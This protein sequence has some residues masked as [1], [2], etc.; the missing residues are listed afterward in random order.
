[1]L[2]DISTLW[3]GLNTVQ[4]IYWIIAV[5]STTIFLI[6]LV[7]TFIGFD[8]DTDVSGHSDAAIGADHGIASQFLSFK[9]LLAFF[10]VFAWTGLA[11]ID[12]GLSTGVTLLI[13][14]VCGLL[15]VLIMATIFY[16]MTKLTESGTLEI[17]NAI[18]KIGTVYLT[19]PAKRKAMGKIQVKV[20]GLQ[21][22]DALTDDDQDI[23]TGSVIE[24]TDIV[25]N[26]ILLVTKK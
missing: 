23:K 22:L 6:Q 25:N 3:Q 18:H 24:V 8:H 7:L 21:T 12:S 10:T 13:S 9:N 17:K 26:E 2:L 4:K 11:C 14:I 15:M 20:Q 19:I 5:P 16:Y 1:M